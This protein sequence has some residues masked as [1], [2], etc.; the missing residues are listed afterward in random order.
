MYRVDKELLTKHLMNIKN[1]YENATLCGE[2]GTVNLIRSSVCIQEIHEYVKQ[3]LINNGINSK[4]IFPPLK[5]TKPEIKLAGFLK[6]KNQDITVLPGLG[7]KETISQ[8]PLKNHVDPIGRQVMDQTMAINCR[9]QMSSL[10]KNFDTLAE[11]TFAEALNLH[12]KSSDIVLGE[13]YLVPII[14]YDPN[15]RKDKKLAYSEVLPASQYIRFFNE[16][17]NRNK[18]HVSEL[19]K[20]EKVCLL[21]VDFRPATPK[22]IESEKELLE[23]GAIKAED[24]N[25][26]LHL[27]QLLVDNFIPGLLKIY[28]ERNGSLGPL[29]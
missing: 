19:Y 16:I 27:E 9:S 3:E 20:Y 5:D 6:Y 13:I 23:A 12:L 10:K 28:T 4:K 14:A 22:I 25:G 26:D 15:K 21:I 29:T 11:R 1:Y 18:D 7:K 24:I 17:N 2:D 8:G